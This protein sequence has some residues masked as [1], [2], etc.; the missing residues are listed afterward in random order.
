MSYPHGHRHPDGS[1]LPA[2]A[3]C[4]RTETSTREAAWITETILTVVARAGVLPQA[5]FRMALAELRRIAD[6]DPDP[7][8][9]GAIMRICDAIEGVVE[10]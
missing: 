6:E 2:C 7:T 1:Y 3:H 5:T 8:T 9:G 10:A 4:V